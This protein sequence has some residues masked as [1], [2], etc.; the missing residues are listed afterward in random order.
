MKFPIKVINLLNQNNSI[1]YL[2][3][4]YINF[5]SNNDLYNLI[6][7]KNIKK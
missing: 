6:I 3:V 4:D 7:N 2:I 5:E 1:I